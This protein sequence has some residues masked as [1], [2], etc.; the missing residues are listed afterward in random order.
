MK[1][2]KNLGFMLASA[3]MI[4]GMTACCD[5]DEPFG[6]GL[7]LSVSAMN[8]AQ[9][10]DTFA[11]SLLVTPII[12]VMFTRFSEC[13]AEK[14]EKEFSDSLR[15]GFEVISLLCIPIIALV[16]ASCTDLVRIVYQRG[17]FNEESV[18]MTSRALIFYIAGVVFYGY[19]TLMNRA[20]YA[21]K[22][23]KTPMITGIIYIV[24]NIGLNFAL[25]GPM[26]IGGL[27]LAN[28]IALILATAVMIVVYIKQYGRWKMEGSVREF[29]FIL[30]GTAV[31]VGLYFG[32][33]ALLSFNLWLRF[34]VP[35][36]VGAAGYLA[37][38][39]IFK[40]KQ[41][42]ELWNMLL[43]KLRRRKNG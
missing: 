9:R 40:V 10:I 30:L 18:A 7:S 27:A 8:Y 31:C 4:F 24:M 28:T 14:R 42:M 29:A 11:M 23:T 43:G 3:A 25:I 36:I 32:L 2:I 5:D 35:C 21:R 20:F 22:N 37:V 15:D 38:M 6:G 33:S 16:L 19:K 39:R 41:F 13:A 1:K 12:T 34:F 17:A 26:G